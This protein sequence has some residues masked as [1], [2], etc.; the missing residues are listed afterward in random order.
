MIEPGRIGEFWSWFAGA[1]GTFGE[2]FENA[3]AIEELARRIAALGPFTWEMGPGLKNPGRILLVISPGGDRRLL[4]AARDIV[5]RAPELP[6][7]EFLPAR[8]PKDWD[9][10]ASLEYEG[11]GSLFLDARAWRYVAAP[12]PGGLLDFVVCAP[13]LAYYEDEVRR[14]AAGIILDGELGEE[15]RLDHIA[16]IDVVA[17][18]DERQDEVARPIQGLKAHWSELMGS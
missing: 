7:W 2:R 4:P 18:F 8:P 1:C 15:A 3:A 17:E 9:L 11:V 14:V 16:G 13:E 6:G 10:R 5:A 12:G